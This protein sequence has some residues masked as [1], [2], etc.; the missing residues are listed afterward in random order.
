MKTPKT[1]AM[2]LLDQAGVKY[3]VLT[4]DYNE[5]DLSGI[6][7]ASALNM[8]PEAVYKTLVMK[9]DRTGFLVCCLAV[10]QEADLKA[11]AGLSGDKRVEMIPQK[12]LL[13]LTGYQ[14]GGCSPIGPSCATS[15]P[16][17]CRSCC[18]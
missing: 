12:D 10:D 6:K 4:Y 14:R 18:R 13:P 1:N 16:R 5:N 9:G 15:S 11:V 3:S 7:A 17:C 8:P 2:R